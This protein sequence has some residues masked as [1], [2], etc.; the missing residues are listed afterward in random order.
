MAT[1]LC[2][3]GTQLAGP[4]SMGRCRPVEHGAVPVIA[5]RIGQLVPGDEV[6]LRGGGVGRLGWVGRLRLSTAELASR[7]ALWP[8]QIA[9]GA[10]GDGS[11][12]AEA[13]PECLLE[14]PGCVPTAAKWL[15]DGLLLHRPAPTAPL[16]IFSLVVEGHGAPE[17]LCQGDGPPAP[18]PD[19]AALFAVRRHLADRA[20]VVPGPLRGSLDALDNQR[21][22]GWV[23]DGGTLA[24]VVAVE[25]MVDGVALPPVVA[26]MFRA[27]L[28][29][30]GIGD[31][32]RAFHVAFEPWLGR[33]H[34]HLVRVR[35]ALDG[36][37]LPG[38][39]ALLDGAAEL[40]PLLDGFADI[41]TL[42]PAVETAVRALAAR[43][44]DAAR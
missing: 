7:P 39:P 44:E 3:G 36:A 34:R 6:P 18:R 35:R 33:R 13:L 5:Q 41:A 38:S 29:A 19:D 1:W 26:E 28:A 4:L 12:A 16:D 21:V 9:A 2:T 25:V 37:D 8:V 42:R 32:R 24:R 17:G 15:V 20:G 30:A 11:P 43:L 22:G 27:D 10:L 23:A 31:G 14:L 40:M